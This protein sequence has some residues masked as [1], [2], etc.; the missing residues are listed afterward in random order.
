M[1]N[2]YST[3]DGQD[4]HQ[5]AFDREQCVLQLRIITFGVVMFL[6]IAL[7]LNGGAIDGKPEITSWGGFGMGV[8]MFA[9][10]LVIPTIVASRALNSVNAETVRNADETESFPLIYPAFQVRHIVACAMLEAGAFLNLVLYMVTKYAGH[11]AAAVVLV[12]LIVIRSAGWSSGFR[13]GYG[14]LN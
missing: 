4:S 3:P 11:L 2:P 9:S 5:P 14:K 1:S 6:G 8:L 13:I 10:H 12:V 7:F